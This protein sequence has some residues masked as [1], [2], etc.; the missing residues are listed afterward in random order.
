[1][2]TNFLTALLTSFVGTLG[3]SVLLHTP[4]RAW[5]PGSC[6][7]AVGYTLYWALIA[8]GGLSEPA[9]IFIGS[10]VASLLAQ[11][12]ARRMR[13]IASIFATLAIIAFVP[14]LGLYR[15]MSLLAQGDTSLGLQTGIAAMANILMITLGLSVG[16][17]IF[18]VI[19]VSRNAR[20]KN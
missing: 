4:R 19:F 5:L 17:F 16:S 15:C 10:L 9:A 8:W 1:M 2:P 13:M 14:G 3:F 7:G 6:I 11:Y 12:A 20:R 18:R